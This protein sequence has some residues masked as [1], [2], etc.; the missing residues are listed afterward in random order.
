MRM[1]AILYEAQGES[2]KAQNILVDLVESNPA[3]KQSVKR[4]VSLYRDM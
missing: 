4:L 1:L 3:D 2:D